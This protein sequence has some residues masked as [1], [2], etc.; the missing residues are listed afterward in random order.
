MGYYLAANSRDSL[1]NQIEPKHNKAED[2]TQLFFLFP[3]IKSDTFHSEPCDEAEIPLM[4]TFT[5]LDTDTWIV[6]GGCT[7]SDPGVACFLPCTFHHAAVDQ[8]STR[9]PPDPGRLPLSP[10]SVTGKRPL[11]T[12]GFEVT[13]VSLSVT[14]MNWTYSPGPFPTIDP[15]GGPDPPPRPP[16]PGFCHPGGKPKQ[17]HGNVW[18]REPRMV[19]GAHLRVPRPAGTT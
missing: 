13:A 5:G 19:Q 17:N 16:N 15:E 6:V 12:N 1:C 8:R 14:P 9:W 11:K 7:F 4:D 3:S 10:T 18:S 2:F